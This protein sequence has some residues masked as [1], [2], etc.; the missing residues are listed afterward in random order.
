MEDACKD[1]KKFHRV[2]KGE[3]KAEGKKPKVEHRQPTDRLVGMKVE[4]WLREGGRFQ[5][6]LKEAGEHELVLEGKSG[7]IVVFKHAVAYI[8]PLSDVW[9]ELE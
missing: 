2:R 8:I 1:M 6:T 3:G 5:G 4:V 9:S 7:E